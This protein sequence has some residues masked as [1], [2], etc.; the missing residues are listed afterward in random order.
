MAPNLVE[1]PAD[2]NTAGRSP[3][4]HSLVARADAE[5]RPV[6]S[7]HPGAVGL[8]GSMDTRAQRATVTVFAPPTRIGGTALESCLV[9]ADLPSCSRRSVDTI[10]LGRVVRS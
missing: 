1:L 3:P 10:V 6:R 2:V 4:G 5:R 7:I 9:T 8:P